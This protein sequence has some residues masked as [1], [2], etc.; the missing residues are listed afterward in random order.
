MR[1]MSVN[2]PELEFS[3]TLRTLVR[4]P[5]WC[6]EITSERLAPRRAFGWQRILEQQEAR[7]L[8]RAKQLPLSAAHLAEIPLLYRDG[9][10]GLFGGPS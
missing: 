9:R 5:Y 3:L 8:F 10:V 4:L 1:I 6:Y 2:R 7:L